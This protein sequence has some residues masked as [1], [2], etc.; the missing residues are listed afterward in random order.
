M[1]T[2]R[3]LLAMS[4]VVACSRKAP[5]PPPP[6]E[7]PRDAAVAPKPVVTDAP[8][9]AVYRTDTSDEHVD[10]DLLGHGKTFMVVSEAPLASKVGAD[11]LASGGNA[12]DAAVA[13]AF[14]LA[15]VHP[16]AGNL[17]GGGFALVRV[18]SGKAVAL[19]F[20]ETAPGAAT[21][22][23][24]LD[25][26]GAPTKASLVFHGAGDAS[27]GWLVRCLSEF[28]FRGVNLTRIESRPLRSVLGHYL[29]HVD[30]DGAPGEPQVDEALHALRTHCEEVRVLGAYRAAGSVGAAAT[31]PDSHGGYRTS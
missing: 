31:L 12:V 1:T 27:P 3:L 4:V 6:A 18:A 30:L 15:V 8:P 28:A 5:P 21:A 29:F 2:T 14:A 24:Y 11:I 10:P 25:D 20:R 23:M 13:T 19:D 26:K 22:D 9:A 17:G 16:S 7:P